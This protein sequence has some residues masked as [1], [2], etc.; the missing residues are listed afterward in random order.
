MT[1]LILALALAIGLALTCAPA[2]AEDTRLV[3]HR[4]NA[5]EVVRLPGRMGVQATIAF[6]EDEHIEN[7][8]IGDSASWQITPNKRANLLFTKPLSLHARTNMTVVTDRRSY[9]FDLVAN[10]SGN[11]LYLLQ[12]SYPD[13]PRQAGPTGQP[14]LTD[15]EARALAGKVQEAD[16][17]RLN[18]AWKGKGKAALIPARVY[19]DGQ[20]TYLA[21]AA[22]VPIPAIQIRNEAGVEGPINFAVR[23]DVIVIDGVP[24][25]IV[26]RAGHEVATLERAAS[27]ARPQQATA[28]AAAPSPPAGQ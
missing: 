25:A 8:A 22:R 5:K 13:E 2:G 20:S 3:T 26:L 6:A 19:D 9:Y 23:D 18:F 27:P 16:P 21:W 11:A 15:D 14:A 24:A 17:A 28:L 7:V 1:R 4:Y 10:P 12:F